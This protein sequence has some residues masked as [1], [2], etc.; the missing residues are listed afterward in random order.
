MTVYEQSCVYS[1][2]V[3]LANYIFSNY[4]GK[5]LTGDNLGRLSQ[6]SNNLLKNFCQSHHVTCDQEIIIGYCKEKNAIEIDT[7]DHTEIIFTQ[8]PNTHQVIDK[9]NLMGLEKY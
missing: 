6:E 8:I 7:L 5:P 2:K 3:K 1:F 4:K 9:E